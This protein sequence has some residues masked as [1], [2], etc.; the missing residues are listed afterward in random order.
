MN[1]S[2]T[3][4]HR[5]SLLCI[6]LISIVVC[7]PG[8]KEEEKW[9]GELAMRVYCLEVSDTTVNAEPNEFA[10]SFLGPESGC[11][12]PEDWD[13]RLELL[14]YSK[15]ENIETERMIWTP[16]D[17]EKTE[18]TI[19]YDWIFIEKI[20]SGPVPKILIKLKENDTQE[21]RTFGLDISHTRGRPGDDNYKIFYGW[22]RVTQK[23]R[24]DMEPF[25][26]K[27]RF[28]DKVYSTEA[29]LNEQEELVILNPEFADAMKRIEALDDIE[30]VVQEEGIVDY[31]DAADMVVSPALSRLR[32]RV[33]SQSPCNILPYQISTRAADG[34]RFMPSSALGY[35][36]MF[37]YLDFEVSTFVSG[38][39]TS[40]DDVMDID[41]TGTKSL[42]EKIS[43]VAI[44]YNGDN[45]DICAV[46]TVWEDKYFNYGDNDRKKH[47]ISFIA[48]RNTP[49]ISW[50]S[51]KNI[52]C[53]GS[54]HTWNDRISSF[55]F[56][57]AY[58]DRP[59]K[60]Y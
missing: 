7:M 15:S 41:D 11:V 8:C 49:R 38:D 21:D 30:A 31:Y 35:F 9:I 55:S 44:A 48:S 57:F 18:S 10:L 52:K 58:Y 5:L 42:N 46:L 50:P 54:S 12:I 25:E 1:C 39:F 36:A 17:A 40:F 33:D 43:S 2:T 23:G 24:P 32:E 53:I 26:M 6:I 22:L 34:F 4:M 47:R 60:D 29:H 13:W 20:K 28:K 27:I 16:V 59:L 56:H 37:D 14:D 51:L 45:S 19:S 3:Y